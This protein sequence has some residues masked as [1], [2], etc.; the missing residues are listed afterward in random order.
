MGCRPKRRTTTR[1]GGLGL[2][3]LLAALPVVSGGGCHRP[4]PDGTPDVPA[5]ASCCAER[6]RLR[7][8]AA[9]ARPRHGPSPR[10]GELPVPITPRSHPRLGFPEHGSIAVGTVTHGYL[11]DGAV[12]PLRGPHHQVLAEQSRRRTN[13][14]AD[15][16][17]TLITTAAA[18][19]AREFSG[20]MLDVGNIAKGGGGDIPW[21]VSHNT[22]LDADLSFYLRDGTGG[23]VH[24]PTLVH[25]DAAGRCVELPDCALDV[26]RTWA[27]V[28]A[29]V[30]HERVALQWLFVAAPIKER[31]LAHAR[32]IGAPR[33]VVAAAAAVLHQPRGALAHDDHIHVRLYCPT[34]DLLDGCRNRGLERPGMPDDGGKLARRVASVQRL[35][36]HRE[37]ARRA[38][39][40]ELLR[41]L[42][43]RSAAGAIVVAL[44]DEAPEVRDAALRTVSSLRLR[45]GVA[46]VKALLGR[47]SDPYRRWEQV[48]TLARLGGVEGRRALLAFLD[49]ERRASRGPAF[50]TSPWTVRRRAA[51]ALAER[52]GKE[53]TEALLDALVGTARG[54]TDSAFSDDLRH[55]LR[56]LTNHAF[57]ELAG[58][59]AGDAWRR[60]WKKNR[61]RSQDQW[62]LEGFRAAGHT[63]RDLRAQS[64]PALLDAVLDESPWISRNAR[65]LLARVSGRDAP[66]ETWSRADAHTYW[67]RWCH[68]RLG[69]RRCAR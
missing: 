24:P 67:T 27:L 32:E 22:G 56:L 9:S 31:L 48:E 6:P 8:D 28:A 14:G 45:R 21:S 3:A 41:V 42:E 12:L 37:P 53:T 54:T 61:R 5:A 23:P 20:A 18:A 7:D 43:A 68:R 57:R 4:S 58:R 65:R 11:V 46:G 26:P 52:G 40:L 38:G 2:V 33:D 64:A 35:L 66:T 1:W 15:E 19:V 44:A 39:A 51:R 30:R 50:D 60:W 36:R 55:A 16:M 47:E 49:D 69:P 17:I 10:V 29:L 25:L 13:Y 59:A 34:D 63:V 62:R